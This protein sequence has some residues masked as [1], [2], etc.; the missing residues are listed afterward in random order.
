[1][2]STTTIRIKK[3]TSDNLAIVAALHN[4]KKEEIANEMLD[5][6]LSPY[7]QKI[8]RFKFH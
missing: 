4:K 6:G 5:A 2:N 1:M 7:I 3:E 8:K